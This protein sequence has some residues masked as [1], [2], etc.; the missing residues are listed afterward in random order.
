[1]AGAKFE[2]VT[3]GRNLRREFNIPTNKKV[4][5]VLK[6]SGHLPAHDAAVIKLL[7]N[8]EA[9]EVNAAYVP[10]QG[11]ADGGEYIG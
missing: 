8:A 9:V 2:L 11:H 1:M 6:P 10:P 5:F 3:L 4:K 7:L